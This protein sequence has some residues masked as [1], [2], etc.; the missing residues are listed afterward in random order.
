M[1]W[2]EFVTVKR[3]HPAALQLASASIKRNQYRL[4][5]AVQEHCYGKPGRQYNKD[6]R[7]SGIAIETLGRNLRACAQV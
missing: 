5:N 6:E 2:K 7:V 4:L 1:R 3:G